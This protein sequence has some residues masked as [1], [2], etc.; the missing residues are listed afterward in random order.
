MDRCRTAE[1]SPSHDS[2]SCLVLIEDSVN[3]KVLLTTKFRAWSVSPQ[4][5]VCQPTN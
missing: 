5:L 4:G 2:D 1:A 3:W